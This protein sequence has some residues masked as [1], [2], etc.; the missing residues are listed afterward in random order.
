MG[1][2]FNPNILKLDDD[3]IIDRAR[4]KLEKILEI[5]GAPEFSLIQRYHQAMPQ[6]HLGH[7]EKVESIFGKLTKYKGLELAGNAYSGVGIPECVRS[8]ELAAESIIKKLF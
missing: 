2:A 8:G 6:Y 3:Q 4:N 5:K 7:T 1:G